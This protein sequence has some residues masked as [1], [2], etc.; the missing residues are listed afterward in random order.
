MYD[1]PE[2]LKMEEFF[3]LPAAAAIFNRKSLTTSQIIIIS[4]H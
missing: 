3:C 1:G 4:Y 2:L